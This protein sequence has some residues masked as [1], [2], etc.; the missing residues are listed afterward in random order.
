MAVNSFAPKK[1]VDHTIVGAD[2]KTV[3]HVRVKPSGILWAPVNGKDWYGVDL[4]VFAQFMKT[5]GTKKK[6]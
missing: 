1:F 5:N 6:K 2:G 4:D 3:G